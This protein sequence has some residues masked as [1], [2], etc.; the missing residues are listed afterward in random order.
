[1]ES[2]IL[3]LGYKRRLAM[4]AALLHEPTLIRGRR[5]K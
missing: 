4:A 1:V 5:A 2:G 3:P